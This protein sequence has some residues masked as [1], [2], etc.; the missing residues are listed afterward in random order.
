MG[1]AGAHS[2][3]MV[4]AFV[5]HLV[6]VDGGDLGIPL[7]GDAGIEVSVLLECLGL[8]G[9]GRTEDLAGD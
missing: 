4:L 8:F 7:A 1:S 3:G 9:P 2:L 6:I 5:D